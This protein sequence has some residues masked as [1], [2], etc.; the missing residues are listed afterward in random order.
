MRPYPGLIAR[1]G[2]LFGTVLCVPSFARAG[3]AGE[4]RALLEDGRYARAEE[5]GL[6]Q[7]E[8]LPACS[9]E[10]VEIEC[11]AVEAMRRGNKKLAPETLALA[12]HA[13]QLAR[14]LCGDG[15]ARCAEP[16]LQLGMV[17]C[18]RREWGTARSDLE[19]AVEFLRCDTSKRAREAIALSYLAI[20]VLRT[21][22]DERRALELLDEA[23]ALQSREMSASAVP[24]ALSSG[25]RQH[26]ISTESA[27]YAWP[28]DMRGV[29]LAALDRPDEAADAYARSLE[30]RRRTQRGD[31]PM[32]ANTLLNL[33]TMRDH[34]GYL[35][36]ARECFEEV[37]CLLTGRAEVAWT[38]AD[39]HSKL[40][41]I[42][43]QLGD[44]E[45]ARW[46]FETALAHLD[47]LGQRDTK[48]GAEQL[49]E[50]ARLCYHSS[51]LAGARKHNEECLAILES[52]HDADDSTRG[53]AL[54]LAAWIEIQSDDL[55]RAN[56]A[57]VSAASASRED[58][59]MRARCDET[60]AWI[61][62]GRGDLERARELLEALARNPSSAVAHASVPSQILRDLARVHFMRGD[63]EQALEWSLDAEQ[64]AS[65]QWARSALLLEELSA[66]G[67][68]E[69]PF[70]ASA[71][72][73]AVCAAARLQKPDATERVWNA[74]LLSR[75]RVFRECEERIE[76]ARAA[77]TPDLARAA[78]RL[79][80]ARER[81][82]GV[83]VR[84]QRS[85][86]PSTFATQIE[87]ARM[88]REAAEAEL[89][90]LARAGQA[91]ETARFDLSAVRRTLEPGAALVSF[92]IAS[93]P[94]A[95]AAPP[96]HPLHWEPAYFACVLPGQH[97]APRMLDIG[98]CAEIDELVARLRQA[99]QFDVSEREF[100]SLSSALSQRIW[101]PIAAH[102]DGVDRVFLVLDGTLNLVPFGVLRDT[103]GAFLVESGPLLH[104]LGS[105]RD[106]CR[107]SATRPRSAGLL[108]LGDP[109]FDLQA[110]DD[111]RIAMATPR[112]GP[113]LASWGSLPHARKEIDALASSWSRGT[114]RDEDIEQLVGASASERE[115]RRHVE[116]RRVI[117]IA[118]HGYYYEEALAAPRDDV[119]LAQARGESRGAPA[120]SGRASSPMT[121]SSKSRLPFLR[122][123]LVLAGASA[124]APDADPRDDGMLTA[125][126][127]LG[128]NLSGVEWVVLSACDTGLGEMRG[129]EGV[130]GLRRAF[131]MAGARTVIAS[132][133]PVEDRWARAWMEELYRARFLAGQS[134]AESMR[135][136]S[137][138]MLQK[139]RALGEEPLPR[140]WASFV[141]VGDWR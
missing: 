83:Y 27:D 29:V 49:D 3:S 69:D 103:A 123:G 16:L 37:L 136:A 28:L 96:V 34:A 20:A 131:R 46:Y 107:A 18:V 30:I 105:E 112:A 4:L 121:L 74:L 114:S 102:L 17:R 106:L 61:A 39:V 119:L 23:E 24:R 22:Q 100:A 1:A 33:G 92:C 19:T 40:G 87:S 51:D 42:S 72:S 5:L 45:R 95:G 85:P 124:A 56:E 48:L 133:W 62:A 134:T 137:L 75:D 7:L 116:G 2:V 111:E 117:H 81:L 91:P 15:D 80:D 71:I 110:P 38:L 31:H 120:S 10:R 78:R 94:R 9:I 129:G 70:L 98:T 57:L 82:S 60:E 43:Q 97:S 35:A 135:T 36:Q 26:A 41:A 47:A 125:E 6:A 101:A 118:T 54:L 130:L 86:D 104:V 21:E 53:A 13:T 8:A 122:S 77:D 127:V 89:A 108:A 14:E 58:P 84:S 132:L 12:E 59:R 115:F 64:F 76:L 11:Q 73:P 113:A 109:D 79:T 63:A 67:L 44:F 93:R 52:A 50:L 88:E 141:A 66:I 140:H 128:L 55:A 25:A 138:S 32:L 90:T 139:L 126:E 65:E 68:Q 99:I